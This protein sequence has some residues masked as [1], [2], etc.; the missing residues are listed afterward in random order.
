MSEQ[1]KKDPL[2]FI[3]HIRDSINEID[4]FTKNVSKEKFIEEKL[5]QNAVIRSIE[6]IGEA[7][8]NL[9]EGFRRKYK[10]IPWNKIAGMRDK[11]IHHYFGVDLETIWKVVKEDIPQLKKQIHK[12]LEKEKWNTTNIM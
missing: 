3:K 11:I 9:P 5:I 10:E 7:V 2:V 4:S 6:V 1:I 8:K 12:I